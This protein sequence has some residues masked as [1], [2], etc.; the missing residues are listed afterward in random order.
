MHR[1]RSY[2]DKSDMSGIRT[3][4]S[5]SSDNQDTEVFFPA[6]MQ[7]FEVAEY[8][9]TDL[10]IGLSRKQ[11]KRRA[12][13]QGANIIHSEFKL[14]FM[15]S[16]RS[17]IKGLL[18]IMLIASSLIMYAFDRQYSY[19]AMAGAIILLILLN[20]IL[21]SR[22]SSALNVP[23]KYTAIKATVTREGVTDVAD[24]RRLVTGDIISFSEGMVIPCDARLIEDNLLTVLETPISGA[25][26]SAVKD[27]RF[28]ATEDNELVYANMVYAGSIVTGGQ[29]S[30]IVCST[31]KDTLLRRITGEK[32]DY[33]P[34]MLKYIQSSGKYI[35]IVTIIACFA[36]LFAGLIAGRDVANLFIISLSVGA[37]SLCDSMASLAAGSLGY[38]AKKMSNHGAVVKNLNCIPKIC[39]INTIMCCKNTAFPPK[40]MTLN[41]VYTENTYLPADRK[42]TDKA[43]ELL[44]LSLACSDLKINKSYGKKRRGCSAFSGRVYDE[45]VAEYLSEKGYDVSSDIGEYFRI[46]TEHSLSGEV[47]RV[48]ILHGGRNVVVLKGAPEF[49]LSR[50]SG[51][52]LNGTGYKM[53]QVTRKRI[54]TAL[55]EYSQE[56]GFIIAIAAGE[57]AAD[58]LRDI[59]AERRLMF[60]GFITLYCSMDVDNASAVYKCS[61]A[62]IETVV[63]SSDSYYT[64]YNIAKNTGI[65]T[66]EKQVVTAEQMHSTDHGLFIANCP[67]YKLF[68]NLSDNEWR[69]IL[70]Y[71]KQDKRIVGVT[72]ERL[73]EL[74]LMNEA[75]VSFVPDSAPD[76]LKQSADVLMLCSGM[77]AL[78]DCLQNARLIFIRIHSVAEYLTVGAA[79]IFFST[80]FSLLFGLVLPFRVQDILFGGILFNLFFAISLAF[81]PTNRKLLLEKLPRYKVRPLFRDFFHPLMYSFGASVCIPL[82]YGIT[83]SFSATICGL[84]LLLFF[85]A[86][87]NISR[88]SIFQKK[89]VANLPLL[90]SLV[91]S[92]GIMGGLFFFEPVRNIFEYTE[93]TPTQIGISIAVSGGYFILLQ[94]IKLWL[95]I[96]KAKGEKL[97]ESFLPTEVVDS[98]NI[99]Q[100][101]E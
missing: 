87:T 28:I 11:I 69:H 82:I 95:D 53:S 36:L 43:K 14:S 81:T 8:L 6:G 63:S 5:A 64:A 91:I 84:T 68:L 7:P 21:E 96:K 17:Q 77:D 65:V 12:A 48:L 51:Y 22:A 52:E 13:K 35:S 47:N 26:G 80:L 72:A 19:L 10:V 78:T 57:T 97:K 85:Y 30:G 29:G 37:V 59:T 76:T 56:S 20:A 60:K 9:D 71:R 50:C 61:Q 94:L 99:T 66:S 100:S 83:G 24:S 39:E 27:S 23:R 58:N 73:E 40:K 1:N 45:A 67:D 42:L 75:D 54:L 74:A 32:A 88:T 49:I 44:Y 18:G 86:L 33:L 25:R 101:E 93:V 3:I 89:A 2:N 62:G 16:I 34:A 98:K 15:Q 46:H 70:K 92:A 55:E 79:T 38:G 4:T 31:G 41:G 90:I